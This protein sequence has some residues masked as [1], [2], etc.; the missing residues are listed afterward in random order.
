MNPHPP[1]DCGEL[2]ERVVAL[3][4]YEVVKVVAACHERDILHGDIKVGWGWGG[5]GG[6]WGWVWSWGFGVWGLG[7]CGGV[8]YDTRAMKEAVSSV[9]CLFG[10]D[11]SGLRC[12]IRLPLAVDLILPTLWTT[13]PNHSPNTHHFTPPNQTS[14]PQPNF[15]QPANFILRD[16]KTNPLGSPN[17]SSYYSQPWLA[18]IDLG[19]AQHL[20][21]DVSESL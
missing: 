15:T 11:G 6:G 16:R 3:I 19:C 2:P 14:H 4:G 18:A 21:P 20:G 8:T 7:V 17:E 13:N 5:V 9:C 1:Q 10:C 12:S